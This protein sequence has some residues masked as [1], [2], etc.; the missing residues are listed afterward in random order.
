MAGRLEFPEV[1]PCAD[2]DGTLLAHRRSHRWPTMARSALSTRGEPRAAGVGVQS[3]RRRDELLP[4]AAERLRAGPQLPDPERSRRC[5][6]PRVRAP[7]DRHRPRRHRE[8]RFLM[9]AIALI[10]LIGL[11]VPL[12]AAAQIANASPHLPAG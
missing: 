5:R 3:G 7:E 8:G 9:Q 6:T 4:A 11:S 12:L 1:V 2:G 10:G